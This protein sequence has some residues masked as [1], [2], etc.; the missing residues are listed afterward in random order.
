MQNQILFVYGPLFALDE[1]DGEEAKYRKEILFAMVQIC[2]WKE[3][4]N[5]NTTIEKATLQ[6]FEGLLSLNSSNFTAII[7]LLG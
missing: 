7:T 3:F 6:H 2:L 5:Q 4:H 1:K